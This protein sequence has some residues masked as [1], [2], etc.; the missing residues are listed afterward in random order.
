[1]PIE[2][3]GLHKSN[4]LVCLFAVAMVSV[5]PHYFVC[6]RLVDGKGCEVSQCA[7]S[8]P[9]L[10]RNAIVGASKLQNYETTHIPITAAPMCFLDENWH[11]LEVE[12]WPKT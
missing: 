12:F 8:V 3:T 9:S 10:M 2:T 5:H 7:F 6:Y 11:N 4:S 1:M